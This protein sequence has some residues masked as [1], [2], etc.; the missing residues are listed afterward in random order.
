MN[1]DTAQV[2]TCSGI[3]NPGMLKDWIKS[4]PH[5]R[6][7]LRDPTRSKESQHLVASYKHIKLT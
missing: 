1:E 6:M 5:T 3:Q 4:E 2:N 7:T